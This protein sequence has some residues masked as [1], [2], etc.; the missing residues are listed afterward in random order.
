VREPL[1]WEEYFAYLDGDPTYGFEDDVPPEGVG[2][3]PTAG[4]QAGPIPPR[5]EETSR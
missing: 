1:I 3:T 5:K 4:V 2:E